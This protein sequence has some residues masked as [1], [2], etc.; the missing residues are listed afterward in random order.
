[1]KDSILEYSLTHGTDY[2]IW[3]D[4]EKKA[5]LPGKNAFGLGS[6][7]KRSVVFKRLAEKSPGDFEFVICLRR[8]KPKADGARPN[9][10][11][12]QT[13]KPNKKAQQKRTSDRKRINNSPAKGRLDPASIEKLEKLKNSLNGD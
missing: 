5:N 1:M 6:N 12:P 7:A 3:D 10:R 4:L 11:K 9:G 2:V 13:K 8:E